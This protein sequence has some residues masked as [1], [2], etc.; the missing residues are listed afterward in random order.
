MTAED[1]RVAGAAALA[2]A[3]GAFALTPVYSSGAWRMPVLAVIVL[4]LAGGLL[5]RTGGPALWA[6]ATR[7]RPVPALLAA[8]G[9]VLVPAGQL[10]L[11]LCM[12]TAGFAP[13]SAFAGV[14]PTPSSVT[15]LGRVLADGSAE[16]REQATPALALTGL[17]ALTT[18]FVG[19]I[20]VTV[21][22]VAVAGRQA[23]VG[24]LALL[25]LYCVPVATITGGIGLVAVAAPSAGLGL[26]L[27][28]D[29][30][31]RLA[32]S[33]RR[34]RT[35]FGAGTAAALRI[36][37]AA[38]LAGLV[39]GSIVP[40]LSEGTLATGL[41]GGSGNATGTSLDP[42]AQLQ[43]QLTLA[44]PKDLLTVDGS[45][46]DLGYLRAVT[47][48]E[49]DN[50]NGWTIS[51]LDGEE[52][53]VDDDRLAPLPSGQAGRPVQVT[54]EAIEHV[55]RFLPV[56]TS[57][58]LVEMLDRGGDDWRFD[59][60]ADTIFGRG[61]TTEDQ[62]YTVAA[63][64]LRPPA[65]VLAR[66]EQLPP[67]DDVQQRFG[68]LPTLDPRVTDQV[69]TLIGEATGPFERVRR[70]HA[71]LTNRAEGFRYSLAT[72][73]GTSGDDLVD[74][75]R[76]RRGYCEQY[77]AAMTVMVRAAGVPARLALGYTAGTVQA[78][79]TRL[80]TTD[81]AHAWVEVYFDGVGWVPFEP[82]PISEDRR[83]DTPWAPRA[84]AVDRTDDGA[85]VPEPSVP[86]EAGPT[87]RPDRA[88]GAVPQAQLR[89]DDEGLLA[90]LLPVAGLALLA[91]AVLAAPAGAR[92]LQRRR[93]M[94]AG[95]A[96]ALWDELSATA[97]DV[98]M[99][100]HPAWTPRQ[101]AREL[102]AVMRRADGRGGGERR[103]PAAGSRRGVRHLRAP[104]RLRAGP[105]PSRPPR[106]PAQHP[107]CTAGG[108]V[109][110]RAAAR[111]V[112]A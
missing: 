12:L 72:K 85:A 83:A 9:V 62:S 71:F 82:T 49:Y 80:I 73:Q 45:V 2:T 47:L 102:S 108:R 18:L 42:V 75:L 4:V 101:A 57:P 8:L 19:L 14:L 23:A 106:G 105:G 59:P 63:T 38:L 21:D 56:P 81:D 89:Q 31:R 93:R 109:A 41:G 95:T 20:A 51:N 22:L 44:E 66:A 27:W 68:A 79:G 34:A 15:D 32:A 55:D 88:D 111:P 46:E 17:L 99:R 35:P 90:Q 37:L 52:S 61:V 77:A 98:G 5:M 107:P 84:D 112:V 10:Y 48:D 30:H 53:I 1:R 16:L 65:E 36:G 70:I 94:A 110:S 7:G 67:G 26:L 100:M 50:E 3:L 76:L 104:Q 6:R 40:T 69:A 28:A 78:D 87:A 13:G 103:R 92:V 86:T 11:V 25:V 33:G 24:G 97:R 43:G 54:I 58:L 29:Q 91:A 64:E 74:F 39:V 96:G 60:V